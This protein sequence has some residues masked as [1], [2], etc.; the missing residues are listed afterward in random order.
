MAATEFLLDLSQTLLQLLENGVL[1]DTELLTDTKSLW[2][3]S[4]VLAA[5]SKSLCHAFVSASLVSRGCQYKI[6]LSGC[7][8]GAVETVLRFIYTGKLPLHEGIS[9]SMHAEKIF[10]VCTVLGIPIEKLQQVLPAVEGQHVPFQQY[11]F[12][13]IYFL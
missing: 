10:A 4:I 13:Y 1:C 12:I 3:H 8:P 5:A 6:H 2:A 9:N 11:V 7:E